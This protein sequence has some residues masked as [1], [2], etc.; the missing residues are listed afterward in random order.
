ML[1][2]ADTGH[3]LRSFSTLVR[4]FPFF[5]L[6][7]EDGD[8]GGGVT[9]SCAL[10]GETW[11]ELA[12]GSVF[13]LSLGTVTSTV[14]SVSV[15][16]EEGCGSTSWHG[17]VFSVFDDPWGISFASAVGVAAPSEVLETGRLQG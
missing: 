1:C 2:S 14:L 9:T 8:G 12:L 11:P 15:T 6:A 13:A 17:E 16:L 5:A 3:L 4:R 7:S 10:S